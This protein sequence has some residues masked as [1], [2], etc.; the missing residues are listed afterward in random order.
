MVFFRRIGILKN[1]GIIDDSHIDG[2]SCLFRDAFLIH[3]LPYKLGS[4]AGLS[5]NP[6]FIRKSGIGNMMIDAERPAGRLQVLH[7][8][9]QTLPVAG[10]QRDKQIIGLIFCPVGLYLFRSL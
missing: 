8:F 1:P 6:V 4:G 10:I 5:V 2:L 3:G 9:S 7:R